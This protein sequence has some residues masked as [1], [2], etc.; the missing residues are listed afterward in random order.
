MTRL[1]LNTIKLLPIFLL[2]HSPNI[3]SAQIGAIDSGV[4]FE[5]QD[6]VAHTWT[7]VGD[8]TADGKD[9]DSNGYIDDI[10]GWNFAEANNKV[11]DESYKGKF[12]PDVKTYFELQQKVLEGTASAAEKT[13][14][15][16]K[17]KNQT[18]VKELMT[19]GSYVHG[20]HVAGIAAKSA[21]LAKI[22]AAKIIP[23]E[24]ALWSFSRMITSLDIQVLQPNDFIE[25]VF[26]NGTLALLAGQQAQALSAVGQYMA[27]TEMKVANCSFGTSMEQAKMIVSAIGKTIFQR[28]LKEDEI[29]TYSKY[30]LN[31]VI[32]K[33]AKFV[34]QADKT[35]FVMA[36][37][38][39]G[40]DNDK[41]PVFPANLKYHNTITV[42]ATN[43]HSKLASFSNY[44]ST[45]VEIAAP[46]VGIVSSI[47][48]SERLPL[49]G[50]SQAA[51]YI[52]NIAGRVFDL[53]PQLTLVEVK[54]ILMLTVDKK[55]FLEG[56][57]VSGGIANVDRAI[58]AA[59]LSTSMSI[60]QAIARA[61]SEIPDTQLEEASLSSKESDTNR[62][63]D[64]IPIPLPSLFKII[65]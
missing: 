20:T 10:H 9:N 56:K 26:M 34:Q 6:L 2:I 52:S 16:E 28:D 19:F 33:G 48:G 23:T 11:F 5:H 12:S 17:R 61:K 49:S 36:S 57:V 65:D 3:F 8:A 53:N 31:Q 32:E 51:P 25:D 38:N 24:V 46:G 29:Q 54:K 64:G 55:L 21:P 45:Q 1:F 39:D 59:Q 30:F 44:G 22:L 47:P 37:G 60:D 43:G 35:L 40:T 41:F 62:G 50:T 27:K 42:A 7:N 4:D 13:W 14:I 18:F 58:K 15:E 63:D